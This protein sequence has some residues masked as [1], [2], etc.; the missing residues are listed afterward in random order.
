MPLLTVGQS[1][2]DRTSEFLDIVQRLKQSQGTKTA[3]DTS[4][5]AG[6]LQ[7]SQNAQFTAK[8]QGMSMRISQLAGR[9]Q[10]LT[11]LAK[12]TTMYNDNTQQVNNLTAE[13]KNNLQ[14]LNEELQELQAMSQQTKASGQGCSHSSRVVDN[15]R[16]QLKGTTSN[17]K[18][19]LEVR[20]ETLKTSQDRRSRFTSSGQPADHYQTSFFDDGPTSD[21]VDGTVGPRRRLHVHARNNENQ[22]L[23][24]AQAPQADS[25][26]QSRDVA[27]R[28]INSTIQELG[29]IFTQMAEMVQQQGEMAVRIDENV[30]NVVSNVDAAQ[31]QLLKYLQ[32]ISSNR[33]LVLKVFGILLAFIMLFIIVS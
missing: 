13:V 2:K 8:A 16:V 17:F 24:Q 27:L 15:L 29:G 1:S 7:G 18:S 22:A 12:Q 6:A 30:D 10:H 25:Y 31:A 28:Q 32:T 4:S 33:W 20:R 11:R 9:I 21:A 5:K 3:L 14:G 26:L 23:L 19:V